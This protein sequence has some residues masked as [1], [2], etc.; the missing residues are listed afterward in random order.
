MDGSIV[1]LLLAAL[2]VGIA[3]TWMELRASLEPVACPECSHCHE[4][5]ERRRLERLAE[6]RRREE[7]QA[8]N[9]RRVGLDFRARDDE[10]SRSRD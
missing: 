8:T 5:D 10:D 1:P 3:G 6:E 9:A 4:R 7:F 2:T